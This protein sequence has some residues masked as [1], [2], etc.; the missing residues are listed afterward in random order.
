VFGPDG[1]V[2]VSVRDLKNNGL[3]GWYLTFRNTDPTTLDHIEW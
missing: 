2:Y 1:L 3:G